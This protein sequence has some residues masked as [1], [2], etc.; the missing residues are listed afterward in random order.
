MNSLTN[1]LQEELVDSSSL[2]FQGEEDSDFSSLPSEGEGDESLPSDS[3]EELMDPAPNSPSASFP[4]SRHNLV[5]QDGVLHGPAELYKN[6]GTCT[7]TSFYKGLLHGETTFHDDSGR[8]V[9]QLQFHYGKKEGPYVVYDV[10]G[11]IKQVFHYHQDLLE[12]PFMTYY[13]TGT[14]CLSGTYA[15]GKR[16]GEFVTY[17]EKGKARKILVFDFGHLVERRR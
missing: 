17:D 14:L 9:A 1:T 11:R 5:Y 3:Q 12:G 13:P 15:Q 4:Q 10:F 7:R 16:H 2:P 6:N 8:V